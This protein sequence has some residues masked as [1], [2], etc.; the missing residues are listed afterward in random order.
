MYSL[1]FPSWWSNKVSLWSLNESKILWQSETNILKFPPDEK[2]PKRS[3]AFAGSNSAGLGQL[4]NTVW[5]RSRW[6][7]ALIE[8]SHRSNRSQ[9]NPS[10]WTETGSAASGRRPV[11]AAFKLSSFSRER[12]LN[13]S[14]RRGRLFLFNPHFNYC[15]AAHSHIPEEIPNSLRLKMSSEDPRKLVQPPGKHTVW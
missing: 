7:V 13:W 11:R 15:G 5:D 9:G 14:C 6:S 3:E 1:V 4:S 10:M 8:R 12:E 2:Q